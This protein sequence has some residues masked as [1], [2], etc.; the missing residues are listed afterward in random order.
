MKTTRV[1]ESPLVAQAL[2]PVRCSLRRN[3]SDLGSRTNSHS[4]IARGQAEAYAT[5]T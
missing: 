2:L 4:T 3:P 5:K 1:R